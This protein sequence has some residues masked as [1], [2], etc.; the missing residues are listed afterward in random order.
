VFCPDLAD[1][2]GVLTWRLAWNHTLQTF[3]Q[4][5]DQLETE[6]GL[7]PEEIVAE[8]DRFWQAS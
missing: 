2:A 7:V 5:L 6:P 1:K 8:A 4:L 3:G